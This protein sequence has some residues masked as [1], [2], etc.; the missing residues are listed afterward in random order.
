M[1][2][3]VW[4]S[5]MRRKTRLETTVSCSS[6]SFRSRSIEAWLTEVEG[7]VRI[8]FIQDF[9]R[10]KLFKEY[11]NTAAEEKNKVV[12]RY[13]ERRGDRIFRVL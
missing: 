10:I 12:T 3:L 4:R 9:I 11:L 8:K 13:I 1:V 5:S 2:Q 7:F 6:S